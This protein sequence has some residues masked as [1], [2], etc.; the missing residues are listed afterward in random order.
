MKK[1]PRVFLGDSFRGTA[2]L[3]AVSFSYWERITTFLL[4]LNDNYLGDL[5]MKT[6]Y[7]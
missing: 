1:S 6:D 7:N 2:K 4:Q 5:P 3:M